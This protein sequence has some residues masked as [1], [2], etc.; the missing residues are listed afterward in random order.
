MTVT[1]SL[2][3]LG[4]LRTLRD[5]WCALEAYA[6]CTY[7]HSWSWIG[8]WLRHVAEHARISKLIARDGPRIV[9]LGLAG[10]SGSVGRRSLYLQ[11]TRGRLGRISS[12]RGGFL[13]HRDLEQEV[14]RAYM[15]FLG[16][17]VADG[18]WKRAVLG[19]VRPAVATEAL[20]D[21]AAAVARWWVPNYVVELDRVREVNEYVDLLGN[22]TRKNMRRSRRA[23]ERRGPVRLTIAKDRAQAAQFFDRLVAL[24][25]A[26]WRARGWPGNFADPVVHA[27]HRDLIGERAVSGE[28]QLARIA[29][30]AEEVGYLYNLVYRDRVIGYD[31]GVRYGDD[32]DMQP[33]RMCDWLAIE[34]YAAQGYAIYDNL[35]GETQYK[36]SLATKRDEIVWLLVRR[37]RLADRMEER[38]RHALISAV[39]GTALHRWQRRLR[40]L[41]ARRLN[42]GR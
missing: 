13:M 9:G 23:Y 31:M 29:A 30:G 2:E 4:D 34:H 38:A 26:T 17:A 5:E 22:K 27:F 18:H 12:E 1:I 7:Y 21:G 3:P 20:P 6:D 11:G 15:R 8:T 32:R 19:W 35:G 37:D 24:H 16:S 10:E 25:E 41:V 39:R 14:R 40:I 28:I 42:A 36:R 33:G